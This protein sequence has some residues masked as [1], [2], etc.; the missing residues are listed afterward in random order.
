V[1]LAGT[2]RSWPGV[3]FFQR[4]D[5]DALLGAAEEWRDCASLFQVSDFARE[6]PEVLGSQALSRIAYACSQRLLS[7]AS[8]TLVEL[9][10]ESSMGRPLMSGA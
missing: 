6:V 9:L 10:P 2:S 3:E 7:L 8:G 5:H 1:N 4:L